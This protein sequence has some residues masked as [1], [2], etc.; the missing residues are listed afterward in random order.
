[1]R[2]TIPTDGDAIRRRRILAGYTTHGLAAKAEISQGH[3]VHIEHGRRFGTP[4]V[5]KRIADALGC[6]VEDIVDM[7]ALTAA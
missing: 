2:K 7:D 5:L 4:P 3:L 6:G 1:M